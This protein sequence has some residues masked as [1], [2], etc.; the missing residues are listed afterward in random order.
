MASRFWPKGWEEDYGETEVCGNCGKDIWHIEWT[1]GAQDYIGGQGWASVDDDDGPDL[2]CVFWDEEQ[3]EM[4]ESHYPKHRYVVEY[5]YFDKRT[6]QYF[7][8]K[9]KAIDNAVTMDA[10]IEYKNINVFEMVP[11][12]F[13][14]EN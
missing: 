8:D 7:H 9:Q 12:K 4:H 13:K 6:E 3:G 14:E 11:I 2:F 10:L 5:Y 1:N